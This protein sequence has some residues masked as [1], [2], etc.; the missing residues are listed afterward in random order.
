MFDDTTYIHVEMRTKT[1]DSQS[2][3]DEKR[4][5][6]QLKFFPLSSPLFLSLTPLPTFNFTSP[7]SGF[8]AVQLFLFL[9]LFSQLNFTPLNSTQLNSPRLLSPTTHTQR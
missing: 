9:S 1:K 6:E 8:P 5:N 4:I 2:T 7:L 3:I